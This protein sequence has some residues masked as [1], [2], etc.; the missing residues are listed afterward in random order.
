MGSRQPIARGGRLAQPC[1]QWQGSTLEGAP[2]D[3]SKLENRVVLVTNVACE[4][5]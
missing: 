3:F 2:F 1:T 4:C 5:G